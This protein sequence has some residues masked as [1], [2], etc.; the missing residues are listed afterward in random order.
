MAGRTDLNQQ[1][2]CF[3][4][5][6]IGA[7]YTNTQGIVVASDLPDSLF[8]YCRADIALAV[9]REQSWRWG[10]PDQLTDPLE[11]NSSWGL[12]FTRDELLT[13][14]VKVV[15]SL[16]FAPDN[17]K[18]NS[19]LIAAIRRWRQDKRFESQEET[20]GILSQLLGPMVEKRWL[21]LEK[22]VEQWKHYETHLRITSFC[23]KPDNM[24]AWESY[25]DMHRGVVL[26]F[27]VDEDNMV[28]NAVKLSY[29]PERLQLAAIKEQLGTIIY[30]TKD[31]LSEKF[32]EMHKI[33]PSHR[34]SEQEWRSFKHVEQSDQ[35]FTYYKFQPRELSAVIFGLACTDEDKSAILSVMQSHH[36]KTKTFQAKV[37]REGY[38]IELENLQG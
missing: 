9:L 19:S 25:A 23:A 2:V 26:R 38:G 12:P 24:L 8:K 36:K 7:F 35:P 28:N 18:G 6:N 17:P 14:L 30:N 37:N 1:T 5:A 21:E 16:I 34:K 15:N 3:L 10:N 29:K 11:P 33:K 22:Q 27:K 31:D 32:P 13:Q 20:A 4:H